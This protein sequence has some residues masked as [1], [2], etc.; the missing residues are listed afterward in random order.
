MESACK[1]RGACKKLRVKLK[2]TNSRVLCQSVGESVQMA[3]VNRL[4]CNT[5]FKYEHDGQLYVR[6][7]TKK[8]VKYLKCVDDSCPGRSSTIN[9]ILHVTGEQVTLARQSQR[10]NR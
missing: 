6:Y 8:G 10:R 2:A 7:S 3:N 9:G 1:H 5:G 4:R